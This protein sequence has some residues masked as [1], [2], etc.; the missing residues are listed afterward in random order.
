MPAPKK[1][2]LRGD[3]INYG[4]K[5]AD[6]ALDKVRKEAAKAIIAGAAGGLVARAA[7]A[8]KG[9]SVASKVAKK[10]AYTK[11][12]KGTQGKNAE[13]K[14]KSPNSKKP[15]G[16]PKP[17]TKA[18][19]SK[20]VEPAKGASMAAGKAA[21][22]TSKAV[23]NA[24]AVAYGAAKTVETAYKIGKDQGKKEAKKKK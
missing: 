9:A 14:I 12:T 10:P 11:T 17:G 22:K 2:A 21:K 13:I 19:I 18:S 5:Q 24:A 15:A 7:S 1:S 8:V 16:T 23:R 4:W 20:T 6:K 3:I